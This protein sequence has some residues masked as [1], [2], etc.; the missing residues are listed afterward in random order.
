MS[1][2]ATPRAWDVLQADAVLQFYGWRDLVFESWGRFEAPLW[3]HYQLGG[4]PLL[5]NSQSGAFYPL[6]ILIG[7][8]HI[9]T[10][11]GITLLAYLHLVWA[12]LGARALSL[13]LGACEEG[14]IAAGILLCASPFM[15]SWIGLASVVTTVCWIPWAITGAIDLA[16][17]DLKWKYVFTVGICV[18]M[19]ILGGHLQ[20][21]T[22]GCLAI[23]IVALWQTV[24]Q[25]VYMGSLACFG[26]I[27]VGAMIAGPQLLPTIF[28][29]QQS[30]RKGSPSIE[31]YKAYSSSAVQP[32]ELQGLAF[33]DMLGTP[34][35]EIKGLDGPIKMP[36]YWPGYVKRGANYAESAL[37]LGPI[38]LMLLCGARYSKYWRRD[39]AVG[40]IGVVGLL[41]ALGT[42]LNAL[43]YFYM[44]GWSSTG[45]PGRAEVLFVIA[46][47]C[48]ASLGW[49]DF[50]DKAREAWRW[51]LFIGI[52]I[53]C[54]GIVLWSR[55]SMTAYQPEL[56]PLLGAAKSQT[57]WAAIPNSAILTGLAIILWGLLS[58]R[59]DGV[60]LLVVAIGAILVAGPKLV[61][62]GDV[63]WKADPGDMSKR[64]AFVNKDW[65]LRIG[66]PV[67]VPP[68]IATIMRVHDIGGYDSLMRNDT[69]KWLDQINGE[70]KSPPLANGNMMFIKPGADRKLLAESGVNEIWTLTDYGL[71]GGGTVIKE[72]LEGP[73][74]ASIDG[75]PAKVTEQTSSSMKVEVE[76]PG[77]LVV[78]DWDAP[79]WSALIDGEPNFLIGTQWR[80]VE[81]PEGRH[82]VEF[83]Y[84][85]PGYGYGLWLGLTGLILAFLALLPGRME[86]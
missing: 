55:A 12:G 17:H 82:T 16:A 78:R 74:R 6:H 59:K 46:A 18:G 50:R 24:F 64:Y 85:P 3:N 21:A 76:G 42:P 41:L 84:D 15:V 31:G 60:A 47:C 38:L 72:P 10:A 63:P 44:P 54:F 14:A 69:A 2:Q 34:G 23:I 13:R 9:P 77:R 79:G 52:L 81:V 48:T 83:K 65:D 66:A 29:S 62:T 27:F 45:S 1:G 20:F 37:Y 33:P 68:N 58:K 35:S 53:L 7:V 26:A 32:F 36:A 75:R 51:G 28:F 4:T 39:A 67:T 22:Y 40:A 5:A 61:P 8:L 49:S 86:E 70:Q 30:H 11:A 56:A 73:G 80:E 19:M 25:K 43:M 71:G 57:F